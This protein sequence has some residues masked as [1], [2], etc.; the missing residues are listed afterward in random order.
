VFTGHLDVI[1]EKGCQLA[2]EV[3]R[4]SYSTMKIIETGIMVEINALLFLGTGAAGRVA[5]FGIGTLA[6]GPQAGT[7]ALRGVGAVLESVDDVLSNPNLLKGLEPGDLL[8]RLR[9]L[10][11]GWHIETLGKGAHKGQ[12]FV[13]REYNAAGNATG[14]MIRWHPG[15][16][17]HGPG[18][19]WRVTTYNTR[20]VIIQ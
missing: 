3:N 2:T 20:S 1:C 17:H 10:P 15:G 9:Q 16:G 18:S 12:G 13:L 11:K 19:Y 7:Q 5:E 4:Q 8:V 14:R 6:N